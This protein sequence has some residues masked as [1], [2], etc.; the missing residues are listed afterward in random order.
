[1]CSFKLL[2]YFQ[3]FFIT[4]VIYNKQRY[5]LLLATYERVMQA[6]LQ[7]YH[8]RMCCFFIYD[9]MLCEEH[10][11][12]LRLLMNRILHA[13]LKLETKKCSFFRHLISRNK[14]RGLHKTN[15]SENMPSFYIT[16]RCKTL[17]EFC[18]T[19][20]TLHQ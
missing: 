6:C 9:V 11:N 16:R 18:R 20:S 1:M 14:N 5:R 8:L 2:V 7:D 15:K 4:Q 19:L 12:N 3:F 17:S 13:N 10:L